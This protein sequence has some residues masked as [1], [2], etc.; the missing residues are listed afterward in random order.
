MQSVYPIKTVYSNLTRVWCNFDTN[1]HSI[2]KVRTHSA[3]T[4]MAS[5]LEVEAMYDSRLSSV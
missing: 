1:L 3:A 4:G 5:S 2:D